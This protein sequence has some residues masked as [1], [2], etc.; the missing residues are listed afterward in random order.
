M[1]EAIDRLQE[2][3]PAEIYL[4]PVRLDDT[5]SPFGDIQELHRVDLFPSYDE[6]GLGQIS[7]ALKQSG[8]V[9]VEQ[10]QSATASP[11]IKSFSSYRI[12]F[13]RPAFQFPCI[14]EYALPEIQHAI[15]DISAALATRKL[16]SRTRNLVL[17]TTPIG[18][19]LNPAD[20]SAIGNVRNMLS[21]LR[22]PID[23][24]TQLLHI[25][26][27]GSKHQIDRSFHHME[28]HL[29]AL[30]YSG[31]SPQVLSDSI[32]LMDQI[33]EMRNAILKQMNALLRAHGLKVLPHITLSS[34]QLKLSRKLEE[35]EEKGS[36]RWDDFY[37]SGEEDPPE[38]RRAGTIC[39]AAGCEFASPH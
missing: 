6:G 10:L 24:L 11:E 2:I 39:R 35:N 26:T 31:L 19:L 5:E 25:Q 16:Y 1:R 4:I 28:F 33:D 21:A 14:F 29:A 36:Q 13:D 3:P 17:E 23:A 12:L 15:D 7:R 22:R 20:Q 18:E 38:A 37:L 8:A 34:Y 27:A 9:A 30:I 32:A